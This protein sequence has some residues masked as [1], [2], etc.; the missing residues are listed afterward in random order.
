M[1]NPSAIKVI[2]W[3][4]ISISAVWIF[5]GRS[6]LLPFYILVFQAGALYFI[7]VVRR[8]QDAKIRYGIGATM[9]LLRNDNVFNKIIRKKAVF[10]N[11]FTF[12]LKCPNVVGHFV[13]ALRF[14]S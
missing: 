11:T 7:V 10:S 12:V 4:L 5:I 2:S 13:L 3:S 9:W 8:T 6:S 1:P 14:F